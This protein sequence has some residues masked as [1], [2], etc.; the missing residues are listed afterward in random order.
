MIG[1]FAIHVDYTPDGGYDDD[2]DATDDDAGDDDEGGGMVPD[3]DGEGDPG[4]PV[5]DKDDDSGCG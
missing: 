3:D 4:Y 1:S 5:R 2:D